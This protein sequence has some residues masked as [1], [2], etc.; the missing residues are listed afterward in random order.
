MNDSDIRASSEYFDALVKT[1]DDENYELQKAL[2]EA[3][4]E[5]KRLKEKIDALDIKIKKGDRELHH[6]KES[7][8]KKECET[9]ILKNV[10]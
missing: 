10:I 9:D 8:K 5:A 3:I 6:H 4:E 1:K 2:G 7:L